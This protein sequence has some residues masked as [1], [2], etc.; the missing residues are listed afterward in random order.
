MRDKEK[1]KRIRNEL[2]KLTGELCRARIDEEYALICE[3]MIDKMARKRNVPF[4]SGR[5][6]TW[7]AA[8]VYSIGQ[9]NF[10]F[11][12]SFEPY[13]EGAEICSHFGVSRST[14]TNKA[15]KIRE[16]FKMNYFESEFCTKRSNEDN[17]L[18]NMVMLKSGLIVPKD[19]L[20]E[21]A[22]RHAV[23]DPDPISP[24][25]EENHSEGEKTENER[26]KDKKQRSLLEY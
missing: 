1:I 16:M 26:S 19:V 25:E 13:M 8:V 10:L 17:P 11:D 23:N 6:E 4:L 3:E 24:P 9:I 14:V 7:A 5:K 18:K 20:I 12:P 22:L 21:I 15:K 2:K